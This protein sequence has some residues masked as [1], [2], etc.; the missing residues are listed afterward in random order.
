VDLGLV[1]MYSA[2]Y[3]EG[4]NLNLIIGIQT[5]GFDASRIYKKRAI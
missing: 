2:M 5:L 1:T 3:Q 4:T